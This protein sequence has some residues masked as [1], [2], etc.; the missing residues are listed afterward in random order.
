MLILRMLF[1]RDFV[2]VRMQKDNVDLV[3][4]MI[5]AKRV[6]EKNLSCSVTLCAFA[7]RRARV[8]LRHTKGHYLQIYILFMLRNSCYPL[9]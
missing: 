6:S 4:A 5:S 8:T 9:R 3:V 7:Y 1:S 2:L